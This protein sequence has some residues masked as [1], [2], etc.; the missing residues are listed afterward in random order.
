ML[1]WKKRKEY[2]KQKGEEDINALEE[3]IERLEKMDIIDYLKYS[4]DLYKKKKKEEDK[5][6]TIDESISK[7]MRIKNMFNEG[8]FNK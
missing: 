1:C 5:K 4:K 2:L 6:S 7:I 3:K 8:P